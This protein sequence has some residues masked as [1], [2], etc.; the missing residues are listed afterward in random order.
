MG[1]HPDGLRHGAA[2][3]I[4][5]GISTV[6]LKILLATVEEAKTSRQSVRSL[7]GA[8]KERLAPEVL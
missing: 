4:K 2:P 8:A 5:E 3:F 6:E 1:N 7:A